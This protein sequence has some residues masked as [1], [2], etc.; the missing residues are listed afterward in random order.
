[1]K[2]QKKELQKYALPLLILLVA[3]VVIIAAVSA[4]T[5]D[6]PG[7]PEAPSGTQTGTHAPAAS[8]ADPEPE[9]TDASGSE[10]SSEG[11]VEPSVS[12]NAASSSGSESGDNTTQAVISPEDPVV[13]EDNLQIEMV[14]SYSGMYVEDGSGEI[15]SDIMMIVL[16]NGSEQDL[17]L[18]RIQLVIGDETYQ[19]QCTNL[20]SGAAVVLLEQDRKAAVNANPDQAEITLSVFFDSPMERCE[21]A[22]RIDGQKGSLTVTNISGQDITDDIYVYYKFYASDYF[23]GGITFRVAVR[24]GLEAGASSQLVAAHYAPDGCEIVQVTYGQ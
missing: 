5:E 7:A 6:A 3:V 20:R 11:N 12:G 21:D 19:F 14:G 15:L 8:D 9:Q 22:I 2:F 16:R 24:G 10:G 23:Y 4:G 1:M 17:Q 18:A 13:L